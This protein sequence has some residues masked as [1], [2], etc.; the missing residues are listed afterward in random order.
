M[1]IKLEL[2]TFLYLHCPAVVL[3]YM[4]GTIMNRKHN[5]FCSPSRT[6]FFG[7]D[8]V[9]IMGKYTHFANNIVL[10]RAKINVPMCA[11]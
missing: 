6:F 10:L 5:S 4:T 1:L 8:D 11:G 9:A 2:N 7:Y 3:V